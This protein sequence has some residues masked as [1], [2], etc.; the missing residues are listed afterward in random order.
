MAET[1]AGAVVP[2]QRQVL[3]TPL[4]SENGVGECASDDALIHPVGGVGSSEGGE[5]TFG[6]Y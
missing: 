3:A 2:G 5:L 1:D 4:P 6:L